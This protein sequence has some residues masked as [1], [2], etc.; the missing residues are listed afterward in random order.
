MKTKIFVLL[1]IGLFLIGCNQKSNNLKI[2]LVKMLN[3]YGDLLDDYGKV[4]EKVSSGN[5]SSM[6][7]MTPIMNKIGEWTKKWQEKLEKHK[8]DLSV[9]DYN[10]VVKEYQVQV[11]KFQEIL[12]KNFNH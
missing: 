5:I 11:Q 7:E 6:S 9:S 3:E 8:S 2:E 10:D 4:M 12:K 1:T